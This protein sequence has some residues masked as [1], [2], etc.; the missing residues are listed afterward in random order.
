MILDFQGPGNGSC[1]SSVVS[2]TK[3]GANGTSTST[4]WLSDGELLVLLE[5]IGLCG[6]HVSDLLSLELCLVK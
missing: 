1:I 6:C 5:L 2:W 3:G 4:V